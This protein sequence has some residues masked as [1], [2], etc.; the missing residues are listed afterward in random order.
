MESVDNKNAMF[1]AGFKDTAYW[2]DDTCQTGHSES[3][4]P[5]Y[6]DVVIVGSGYTGLHTALQTIKAGRSTIILD[7]GQIGHGCSS[8]NG[9]QISTGIKPSREQ[10]IKKYG[11]E[12][13]ESIRAEG[14]TALSWVTSFIRDNNI[15]CDLEQNG[16][17]QAAHTPAHYNKMVNEIDE[18][19][20]LED[21][22]IFAVSRQEQRSEIGSDFYYGGIVYPRYASIHAAKYH[23][24]LL[25]LA[26]ESGVRLYGNCAANGITRH[27]NQSRERF[28]INTSKGV[29]KSRE[30]MIATNGYTS[31]ITPWFNRRIIP[32]GSYIIATEELDKTLINEMFP[33]NRVLSDTRKVVYYYRASPDR[34]RVLFG[35][36]VSASETDTSVSGPRLHQQMSKIFPQLSETKIS[37]SWM[38]SVGY[39]FDDIPHTGNLNGLHYAMGFCGEGISMASYLGMRSGQKII[40]NP[41]GNTALDDLPFPTR[42][43]YRGNPWFLPYAVS[44]YSWKDERE[45]RKAAR[46]S[47][48]R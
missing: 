13:G 26:Q 41:N 40:G 38:G 9:G 24:G 15:D 17:F 36:R 32:I 25:K 43:F 20:R 22:G 2:L 31:R 47:A 27:Q 30:I 23:R 1:H 11:P 28:T 19:N 10:L 45:T 29:I 16:Y 6:A 42:P 3:S 8:R 48:S 46:M 7:G 34:K 14:N 33:R 35:G 12:R 18:L 37:H 39:T 4:L 5:R 44:W 21:Q